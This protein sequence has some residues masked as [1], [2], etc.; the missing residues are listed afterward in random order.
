MIFRFKGGLFWALLLWVTQGLWATE[1]PTS[2][3]NGSEGYHEGNQPPAMAT[4]RRNNRDPE[5]ENEEEA[6]GAGDFLAAA[7]TV[8]SLL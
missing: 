4:S 8:C 3:S 2:S 7:I 5:P 1:D 6:S